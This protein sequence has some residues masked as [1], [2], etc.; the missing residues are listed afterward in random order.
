MRFRGNE[1]HRCGGFWAQLNRSIG[2]RV[3]VAAA[4]LLVAEKG[5]A[6]CE[7]KSLCN[8]GGFRGFRRARTA[9]GGFPCGGEGAYGANGSIRFSMM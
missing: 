9:D 8:G 3:S 7:L 1:N 4:F 2:W 5:I 6:V